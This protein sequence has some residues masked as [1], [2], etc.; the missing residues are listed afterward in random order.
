ME[1]KEIC[2]C[3]DTKCPLHPV[4]HDKG[5]DLC[6]QKALKKNDYM[7]DD[8]YQEETVNED[9]KDDYL[10]NPDKSG[11][12]YK[13]IEIIVWICYNMLNYKSEFAEVIGNER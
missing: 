2:T 5:C 9:L 11:M 12:V 1:A 10:Y 6:I 3:K 8:K 13:E 4:N 7:E